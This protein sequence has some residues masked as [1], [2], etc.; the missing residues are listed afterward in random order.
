[1]AKPLQ[2]APSYPKAYEVAPVC[3]LVM[4]THGWPREEVKSR[5]TLPQLGRKTCLHALPHKYVKE[6]LGPWDCRP[7]SSHLCLEQSGRAPERRHPTVPEPGPQ[8]ETVMARAPKKS[9][10]YSPEPMTM[11][12]YAAIGVTGMNKVKDLE[13]GRLFW[14][15]RMGPI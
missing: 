1:M 10:P 8:R 13:M 15:I 11:S 6:H 4:P 2:S 5:P 14:V 9:T 3:S 7:Q 12:P